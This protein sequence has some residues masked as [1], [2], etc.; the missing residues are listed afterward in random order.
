MEMITIITF[1]VGLALGCIGTYFYKEW[2]RKGLRE[3]LYDKQLVNRFLKE[4]LDRQK[5]RKIKFNGKKKYYKQKAKGA[6]KTS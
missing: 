3:Q 4:H 5:S 6:G 2:Q 1:C